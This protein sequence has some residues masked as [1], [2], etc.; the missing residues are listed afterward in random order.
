MHRPTNEESY[1]SVSCVWLTFVS[2]YFT[3]E[4]EHWAG[5]GMVTI[6]KSP[7]T[8]GEINAIKDIC[9]KSIE[10]KHYK[11]PLQEYHFC[12]VAS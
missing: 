1:Y 10:V 11:I 12:T 9:L 5:G 6:L 8:V 2:P 3:A 4:V 7:R